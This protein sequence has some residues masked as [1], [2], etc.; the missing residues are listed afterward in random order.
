MKLVICTDS[1]LGYAFNHRR[2]SADLR[3]RQDMFRRLGGA[4][5][6]LFVNAYTERSLLRDGCFDAKEAARRGK[7]PAPSGRAFL[8]AAAE[9][10]GWAFVENVEV[11]GLW[12]RVDEILLYIWDKRYPADYAFPKALLSSFELTETAEFPGRSH[13]VIRLEHY[14]RK[15]ADAR[16]SPDARKNEDADAREDMN[17]DA[18]E[19]ADSGK[20]GRG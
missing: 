13:D 6:G 4:A 3:M 7:N 18:R 15:D 2:Q 17:A 12:H 20:G 5:G 19:N 11:K 8:E 1:R 10:G 16:K 9:A 14:V